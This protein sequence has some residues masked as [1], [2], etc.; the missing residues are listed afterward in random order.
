MLL[1]LLGRFDSPCFVSLV[2]TLHL[3]RFA[4]LSFYPGEFD[5]VYHLA[6]PHLEHHQ[7]RDRHLWLLLALIDLILQFLCESS[8]GILAH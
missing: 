4:L 3:H 6:Q 2:R 1:S 7:Y 8:L 5:L